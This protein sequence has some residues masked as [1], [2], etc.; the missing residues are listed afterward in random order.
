MRRMYGSKKNWPYHAEEL[1]YRKKVNWLSSVTDFN[2][3]AEIERQAMEAV[4]KTNWRQA[5]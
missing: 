4:K 2:G 3:S 5:S 1:L